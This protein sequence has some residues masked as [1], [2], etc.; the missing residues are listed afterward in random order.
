MTDPQDTELGKPVDVTLLDTLAKA[1]GWTIKAC[2]NG[3]FALVFEG[4]VT[5]YVFSQ[6]E[7]T[8]SL[9]RYV[10]K[11]LTSVDAAL[12]LPWPTNSEIEMRRLNNGQGFVRFYWPMGRVFWSI[13]A[14]TLARALCETFAQ[15]WTA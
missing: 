14:P 9:R 8:D 4:V 11:M 3:Q 6:R 13:E 2:N 12:A 15:W 5:A 1:T 10:V 7:A